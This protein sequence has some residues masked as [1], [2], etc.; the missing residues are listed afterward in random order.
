MVPKPKLPKGFS[1]FVFLFALAAS[2][3]STG[4]LQASQP[5]FCTVTRVVDGD[6]LIVACGE[7]QSEKIRLIGVDTPE[8][9]HPTKPVQYF[10]REASAFTK[11][12]CQG[13]EAKLEFDQAYAAKKHRGVY[14][15]LLAYVYI[16][17]PD[18]TW[19]DLNAELIKQGYAHAYTRFPFSRMEE[20]RRLEREAR[21]AG[22]GLWGEAGNSNDQ[23][24][25]TTPAATK[26]QRYEKNG[27][28]L[29][30]GNINS[31]GKKIY[32]LPGMRYYKQTKINEAKGEKWFCTEEEAQAA[33]WRKSNQ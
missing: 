1:A 29:I 21:E 33:G 15:R 24:A 32:H 6:T 5:L 17:K 12:M 13:K 14:G 9:K 16:K 28:C 3:W 4:D 10:G 8:T 11:K 2:L 27:Q 23:M 22:R 19:F 20:F 31:R 26:G 30:K 7:R 25:P 18:G